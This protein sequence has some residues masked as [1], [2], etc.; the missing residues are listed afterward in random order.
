MWMIAGCFSCIRK[1]TCDGF[2]EFLLTLQSGCSAQ[3]NVKL[4]PTIP[5]CFQGA[6]FM[7]TAMYDAREAIIPGSVYDRSS[8][9]KETVSINTIHQFSSVSLW[10]LVSY[11]LQM[12]KCLRRCFRKMG[13]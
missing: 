7:T 3:L 10:G 12:F 2:A 6:R 9:G 5:Q 1:S 8:Q 13:V 11:R 4:C